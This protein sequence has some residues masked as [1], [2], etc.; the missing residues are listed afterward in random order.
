MGSG[1]HART[2]TGSAGRRDVTSA[3]IERDLG[4]REERSRLGVVGRAKAEDRRNV[5]EHLGDVGKG[6]DPDAATDDQ[7]VPDIE[8]EAVPE[9]AKDVEPVAGMQGAQGAGSRADG[10]DQ[11]AQ[12]A[13]LDAAERH[14]ARQDV[15]R[16]VKHEELPGTPGLDSPGRDTKQRVWPDRFG[17]GDLDERPGCAGDRAGSGQAPV[18]MRSCRESAVSARAFAIA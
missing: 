18:P 15:T 7:R 8:V 9:R 11:K 5:S 4:A 12:L 1:P 10:V 16:R 13:V 17:A 14:R 6:R 3:G 2:S